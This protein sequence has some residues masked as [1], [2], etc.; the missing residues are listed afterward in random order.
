MKARKLLDDCFLHD[1][2]RLKHEDAMRLIRQRVRRVSDIETVPLER[3]TSRIIAQDW[4]APRDIPLF[5]NSAVDGYAFAHASLGAGETRLQVVMRAAA[6]D[7]ARGKIGRGEA[8]RIFTGAPLPEGADS[9]IMQEDV[10]VEGDWI[11]VPPGLKLGA[12]RRKAGEDAAAGAIVVRRGTRLRPQEIAAV[13]STGASAIPCSAPLRAG[14]I[15]TGNEL[16]RPGEA[17]SSSGVYD[18]N[19]SMLRGLLAGSGAQIKDLGIVAD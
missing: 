9:C 3:A 17:L 14:L 4:A 6:G 1:A 16:V 19:H 18:S 11:I 5:T 7:R 12:N 2:E 15:S 13:A 10:K 8:V